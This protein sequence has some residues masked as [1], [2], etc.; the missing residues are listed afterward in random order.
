MEYINP[1]LWW[2]EHPL[3]LTPQSEKKKLN[4]WPEKQLCAGQAT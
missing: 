1:T 4:M 3:K 2:K